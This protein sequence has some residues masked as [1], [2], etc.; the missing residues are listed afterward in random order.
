MPDQ[1]Q[2]PSAPSTPTPRPADT[3]VPVSERIGAVAAKRR[4]REKFFRGD[5][6]G[7]TET[8]T[9]GLLHYLTVVIIRFIL[10]AVG[11]YDRGVRNTEDMRV[12][13]HDIVLPGLPPSF[14]GF[15][16]LHISD[17]HFPRRFPAFAESLGDF[18]DG[19]EVD[20]CALTGDYRYG[21]LG[22]ADHVPEHLQTALRGVH[23]RHG[24]YAVL[25]NHDRLVTGDAL[26]AAGF[27]VLF[28][29][30]VAIEKDGATLWIC[31]ID[32]PHYFRC[33]DVA[34]ALRGRP[35]N[36]PA[37]LLAHSPERVA[38]AAKA[39]VDLYLTGHTH[40]GQIRFPLIGALVSNA[41]CARSQIYGL[42]RYKTMTGYTTAGIG[43]TDVPVRFNC[44]PEAAVLTL[45]RETSDN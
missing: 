36:A 15:Q 35:A 14:D 41:R 43:A 20:V 24:V 29:E 1:K 7:K 34:T 6:T 33:D 11:L 18:L 39:G 32:E 9:P 40:G 12:V 17:F 30:G 27:T 13:R 45:R 2:E 10:R 42:W 8:D 3:T 28:N 5:E 4:K 22:P 44:P 38:K 21:Y 16:I 37:V 25:G 19:I 31:G 26:E 23:A